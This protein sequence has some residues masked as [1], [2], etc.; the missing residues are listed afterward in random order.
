MFGIF[1]NVKVQLNLALDRQIY[2]PGDTIQAHIT[3]QND[4][5]MNIQAGR[6]TIFCRQRYQYRRKTR[7]SDG[8]TSIDTTWGTHD[9]EV[10]HYDFLSQMPL[11]PDTLTFD[12]SFTLEEGALPTSKGDIV[13][14]A[15][16]AKATLDRKLAPDSN[17]EVEFTVVT[18]NPPDMATATGGHYG[19]ANEPDEAQM[20][21][22]LKTKEVTGGATLA[23][24]LRILPQ[25]DFSVSEVRLTLVRDE[26]V[27]DVSN[28]GYDHR[29][30]IKVVEVK[31]AGKTQMQA[32]QCLDF[33]FTLAMPQAM[34]PTMQFN[35]G[36][37]QYKLK[38]ILARTLRKDTLV[39]E[40]ILVYAG[41]G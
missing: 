23:G 12:A 8:D 30:E 17:S 33:P 9:S 19:H 34:A 20:S 28:T 41:R 38:G 39:V 35:V 29:K 3:L 2:A 16:F 6:F 24:S 14:T 37:L 5:E 13:S 11:P 31:L 4:K 22:V 26:Y 18:V 27:S 7:D 36:S 1:K 40:E 10:F 25:K 32:G 15:W 21:F